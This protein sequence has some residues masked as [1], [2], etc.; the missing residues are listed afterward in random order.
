MAGDHFQ[1]APT[2]KSNEAARGGLSTTLLEKMCYPC[3][4][5][6]WTLLDEEYRMN[7]TIYGIFIKKEFYE[8]QV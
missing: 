1:L 2:I 7:E 3:I 5:M 6:R 4:P 8:K